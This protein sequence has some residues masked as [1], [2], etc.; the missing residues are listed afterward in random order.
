M[1]GVVEQRGDSRWRVRVFAGREGGRT[2]WVSR[3]VAGTKRQAD[4]T[5]AEL[6]TEV[7]N[8]QVAKHQP[9]T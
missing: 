7:E 5:L 6:V 1:R 3:T 2:R 4:T 8:D 9:G